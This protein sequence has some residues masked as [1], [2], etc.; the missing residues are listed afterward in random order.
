MEHLRTHTKEKPYQCEICN[1]KYSCYSSLHSHKR[2]HNERNIPCQFCDKKFTNE[3]ALN[4]HIKNIHGVKKIPA[5]KTHK[6]P[7]C[8]V[9]FS[10]KQTV[11]SHIVNIHKA[12]K[13]SCICD[14]CKRGYKSMLS[15]KNH[16]RDYHCEKN[17]I[18]NHCDLKFKIKSALKKHLNGV[19]DNGF[20]KKFKENVKTEPFVC[21]YCDLVFKSDELRRVHAEIVHCKVYPYPCMECPIRFRVQRTL[22]I[23]IEVMH[24]KPDSCNLITNYPCPYCS[25]VYVRKSSVIWHVK[26][27]HG[28]KEYKNPKFFITEINN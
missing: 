23:H 28:K 15:L 20:I 16:K 26:Y 25:T 1:K 13:N 21:V 6:C 18:C 12:V 17:Y 14:I 22:N 11:S 4:S 27:Y 3:K 2:V 24:K 7:Y 10:S 8:T 9:L 5:E 19:K